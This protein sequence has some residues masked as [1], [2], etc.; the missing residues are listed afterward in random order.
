MSN[1]KKNNLKKPN[2]QKTE[3][4]KQATEEFKAATSDF[5][6]KLKQITKNPIVTALFN[7]F[8]LLLIL[9][10]VDLA[11]VMVPNLTTFIA[12]ALGIGD[13]SQVGDM[14][15]W[16]ACSMFGVLCD[17]YIMLFLIKKIGKTI[18]LPKRNKG[19]Q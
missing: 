14:V 11:I 2:V 15:V 5:N 17:F 13:N 9:L 18:S 8:K 4:E 7:V 3:K 1:K 12:A 16:Q 6:A 19:E 10:I